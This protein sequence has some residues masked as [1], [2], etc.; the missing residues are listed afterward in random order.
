MQQ[1]VVDYETLEVLRLSDVEAEKYLAERPDNWVYLADTPLL[2]ELEGALAE[3]QQA[4]QRVE[5][6]LSK[7][8]VRFG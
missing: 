8:N 3:V 4:F 1:L 2:S 5:S 7:A 6:V